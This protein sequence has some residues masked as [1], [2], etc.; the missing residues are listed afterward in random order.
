VGMRM[1]KVY[2]FKGAVAKARFTR[3]ALKVSE[4]LKAPAR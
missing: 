1:Q 4:F 3:R 2:F